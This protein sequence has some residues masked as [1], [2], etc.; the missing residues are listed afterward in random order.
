[1]GYKYVNLTPHAI[2]I[3]TDEK[4]LSG[5]NIPPSGK[6]LRLKEKD[7][8]LPKNDNVNDD[9]DIITREYQLEDLDNIAPII[10]GIRYLVSSLVLPYVKGRNDMFS[11]DTGSGAVRNMDGKIIGTKRLIKP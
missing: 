9:F 5:F 6:I 2:D 8:I 11:P 3:I 7:T 1:M 4:S 10:E